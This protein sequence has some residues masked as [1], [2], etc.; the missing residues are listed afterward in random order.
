MIGKKKIL[1]IKIKAGAV[2]GAQWL[3]GLPQLGMIRQE[4]SSLQHC[5]DCLTDPSGEFLFQR[6][7]NPSCRRPFQINR[8]HASLSN[9]TESGKIICPHCG[10]V[11]EGESTSIF[12]THAL[13]PEEELR[14]EQEQPE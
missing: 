10:L 6:C 11:S 14:F 7:H 8:F 5:G 1:L 2:A 12:L 3:F 13:S 9:V 4:D